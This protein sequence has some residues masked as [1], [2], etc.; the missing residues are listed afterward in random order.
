MDCPA[1]RATHEC[2]LALVSGVA[3]C[4]FPELHLRCISV[5]SRVVGWRSAPDAAPNPAD[6]PPQG[7]D[8]AASIAYSFAAG[9]TCGRVGGANGHT[10]ARYATTERLDILRV[11]SAFA[12]S[13]LWLQAQCVL[14]AAGCG[15]A[16]VS[17]SKAKRSR[18]RAASE[19][20]TRHSDES[21]DEDDRDHEHDQSMN[22]AAD[23]DHPGRT[24]FVVAGLT[25]AILVGGRST[26]RRYGG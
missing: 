25:R 14:R 13:R 18:S 21:G 24:V 2:A 11:A 5:A 4:A 6:S 9:I 10:F 19:Y 15:Y 17:K 3:S 22:L 8:G 20:R 23:Y 7:A 16:V 1:G 12:H 26:C